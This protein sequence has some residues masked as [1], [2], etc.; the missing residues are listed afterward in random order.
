MLHPFRRWLR[1]GVTCTAF[2]LAPV[3]ASA[4]FDNISVPAQMESLD[5]MVG[6][7]TVEGVFR[8]PDYVGADRTLWYLTRSGGITR[9]DGR[10]WTAYGR[11]QSAVVDSVF[12]QIDGRGEPYRFTHPRDVTWIQDGF[13]LSIDEGRTSGT[14]VVFFDTD[15]AAWVATA[16]HAPTNGVTTSMASE[17]TGP[18]IF[19]GRATDRR[20]ERIFRRRYQRHG[21][22]HYTIRTD[23]SFDE[24]VTW[25]DDQ[26]VR[27]VRRR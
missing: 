23:I 16:F 8:T 13:A 25:I 26:M 5:F 12:Q 7:W 3:A 11:R 17:S 9:F 6:Q 10:T 20:G 14:T 22:D 27:E 21:L 19:E 24:G 4:Q 1:V 2:V 18:P 15:R